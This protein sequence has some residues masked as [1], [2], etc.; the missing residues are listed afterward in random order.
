VSS[1]RD[2]LPRYQFE[3]SAKTVAALRQRG[4]HLYVTKDSAGLPRARTVP[5][6]GFIPLTTISGDGWVAH[7]DSSIDPRR[8]FVKWTRIPWPRVR[9]LPA[10]SSLRWSAGIDLPWG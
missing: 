10:N 1:E 2:D 7:V 5:P 9:L 8:W 4:G 3:M 6:E